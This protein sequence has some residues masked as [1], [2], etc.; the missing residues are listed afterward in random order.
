MWNCE[1]WESYTVGNQRPSLNKT[2]QWKSP[3][4]CY[5]L[6]TLRHF[7]RY[8][9]YILFHECTDLSIQS[10]NLAC[11]LCRCL[12]WIYFAVCWYVM[13][14]LLTKTCNLK[15]QNRNGGTNRGL[16]S[17]FCDRDSPALALGKASCC[18]D[19]FQSARKPIWSFGTVIA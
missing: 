11:D 6:A 9:W 4:T 8:L 16:L 7:L 3:L 17:C 14:Y 1:H 10:H 19:W 12:L 2:V 13:H 5:Y 15:Q 18:A